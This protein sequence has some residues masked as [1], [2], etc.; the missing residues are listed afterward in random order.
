MANVKQVTI[1]GILPFTVAE[2]EAMVPY[3]AQTNTPTCGLKIKWGREVVEMRDNEYG[4]K[5]AMFDFELSG[6]EAVSYAWLDGFCK[7]V[8]AAGG[9]VER[10]DEEDVDAARD[11]ELAGR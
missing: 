9:V 6:S 2:C 4:G 7:A 1:S 5:T 10:R 11:R 8:D 3:L